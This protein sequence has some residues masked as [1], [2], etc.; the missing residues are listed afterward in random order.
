MFQN[1]EQLDAFRTQYLKLSSDAATKAGDLMN[2][3][4]EGVLAAWNQLTT[5]T[6]SLMGEK[7]TPAMY[8]Q[9]FNKIYNQLS[10]DDQTAFKNDFRQ[11]YGYDFTPSTV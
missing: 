3:Q 6:A 9:Q 8:Q 10:A 11:V 1:Q 4:S 5:I 7:T 2:N